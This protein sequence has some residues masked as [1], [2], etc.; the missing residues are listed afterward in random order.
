MTTNVD[1]LVVGL[2]PAGSAAAWAAA[3]AGLSVLAIDRKQRIGEPVQCAEFVPRPLSTYT[4]E[5][6]V[7]VQHI[8][9]MN[10]V[11]PSGDLERSPFQGLMV[12]RAEFDRSLA[13][14]AEAAGARVS[15]RT[16]LAWLD[17]TTARL[18]VGKRTNSVDWRVLVAADGPHSQ[19]ARLLGLPALET[20]Q[21][22]QYTVPLTQACTETDIWLSDLYPG[23][24]GWL[25][26]R[27]DRANLGLGADRRLTAELRTPLDRLHAHLVACGRVGAECFFRTGGAIPVSGLRERVVAGPVLFAGDAA[28]LTHPISGA[29]IAAAVQSG[30]MAGD[31]AAAYLG[32]RASALADYESEL[33][34][35]YG[36]SLERALS[37]RA[38]LA[39]FWRKR[40][41]NDDAVQRRG[42]IA[43]KEY[44]E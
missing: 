32:G 7:L 6:G 8:Q 20:V 16:R 25:F 10:S 39:Q 17:G 44:F 14:R 28:G 1:V 42:W 34:E 5:P 22:R 31:A 35:Q 36:P 40:A 26:P 43:F 3:R 21:T 18:Q 37:R 19:V 11:L 24:Y 9:G 41:A 30:E 33:R 29:G 2:G 15:T 13:R 4:A 27:G 23:G 38:W 12:D